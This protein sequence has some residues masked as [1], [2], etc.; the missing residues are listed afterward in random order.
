MF[1][2]NFH[3]KG[4]PNGATTFGKMALYTMTLGI[5]E[6]DYDKGPFA[7]CHYTECGYDKCH[8]AWYGYAKYPCN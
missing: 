4:I 8:Y 3:G 2:R 6:C 5:T 1:I 7:K